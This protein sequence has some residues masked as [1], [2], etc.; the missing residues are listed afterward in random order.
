MYDFYDDF[1]IIRCEITSEKCTGVTKSYCVIGSINEQKCIETEHISSNVQD[2]TLKLTK[3]LIKIINSK[4]MDELISVSKQIT[5]RSSKH[6]MVP[7]TIMQIT[8]FLRN[9][10]VN[11][12]YKNFNYSQ[13]NAICSN[14][15]EIYSK[16]SQI[17]RKKECEN[18]MKTIDEL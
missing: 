16:E 6:Y 1:K 11:D 13:S 12:F 7:E 18:M 14:M 15:L 4:E 10:M 5:Y 2:I 17:L 9:Y 8:S 3:K